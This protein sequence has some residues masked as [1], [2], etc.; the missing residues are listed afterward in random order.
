MQV[1]NLGQREYARLIKTAG[2]EAYRELSSAGSAVTDELWLRLQPELAGEAA[3]ELNAAQAF[4]IGRQETATGGAESF[5]MVEAA[6]ASAPRLTEWR[7]FVE[8][9][10]AALPGRTK[11]ILD[12]PASGRRHLLLGMPPGLSDQLLPLLKP[13]PTPEP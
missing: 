4:A 8:T 12:G 6:H 9:L 13:N 3:A 10:A 1:N 11:L 7:L 2:D 5:A